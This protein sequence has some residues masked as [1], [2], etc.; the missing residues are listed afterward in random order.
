VEAIEN[1]CVRRN[2]DETL[3]GRCTHR[4]CKDRQ[5]VKEA[6]VPAK[7]PG[8]FVVDLLEATGRMERE[9]AELLFTWFEWVEVEVRGFPRVLEGLCL[10]RGAVM[11][12]AAVGSHGC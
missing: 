7:V 9:E 10:L 3:R 2:D 1:V 4:P 8:A 5:G 12:A 11:K 6:G